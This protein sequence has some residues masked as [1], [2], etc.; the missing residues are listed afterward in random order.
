MCRGWVLGSGPVAVVGAC[1]VPLGHLAFDARCCACA[2]HRPSSAQLID[3]TNRRLANRCKDA[4]RQGMVGTDSDLTS[5]RH[6]V[7]LTPHL[8]GRASQE[9]DDG[10]PLHLV[11]VPVLVN[12]VISEATA[13]GPDCARV[14]RLWRSEA[15][16]TGGPL[17]G[18]DTV[19]WIASMLVLLPRA[20]DR[21]DHRRPTAGRCPPRGP[22]RNGSGS[23]LNRRGGRAGLVQLVASRET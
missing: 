3:A 20:H 15:C 22:G 23:C 12:A 13:A 17:P 6:S 10:S 9:W 8:E 16:S 1:D 14:A 21:G 19:T 11:E 5:V 2:W 18:A 7:P 4:A